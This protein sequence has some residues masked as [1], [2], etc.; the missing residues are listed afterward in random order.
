[1]VRPRKES[2]GRRLVFASLTLPRTTLAIE[3]AKTK[4]ALDV[5]VALK[6]FIGTDEVKEYHSDDVGELK[7]A[8]RDLGWP[9]S[10]S[11]PYKHQSHGIVEATVKQMKCGARV[12]LNQACLPPKYWPYACRHFAHSHN[13]QLRHYNDDKNNLQSPWR[14][15]FGYDFDG[16]VIPFGAQIDYKLSAPKSRK[17]PTSRPS[18]SGGT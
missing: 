3:I 4:S 5:V 1:M 16:K 15:R 2:M 7:A 14:R 11:A 9:H 18:S 17:P 10:Q 8:A 13:T 6:H 12:S